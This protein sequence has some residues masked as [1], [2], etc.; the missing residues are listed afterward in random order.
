MTYYFFFMVPK[1]FL[2]AFDGICNARFLKK[3]TLNK[4]FKNVKNVKKT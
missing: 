4:I 1:V 2:E 3:K